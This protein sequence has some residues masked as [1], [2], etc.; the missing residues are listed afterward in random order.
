MV[1]ESPAL[2]ELAWI[3]WNLANRSA[4]C[5]A[6]RIDCLYLLAESDDPLT[7]QLAEKNQ[8][9]L[10]D[11]RMTFVRSLSNSLIVPASAVVRE[12][13][14]EDLGALRLIALKAHRDSRFYFDPHFDRA[15]CDL[16]YETS[17]EKSI[18]GFAKEVLVAEVDRKTVAYVTI[19]LN[20]SEAQ[21]GLLGV[22]E[23]HQGAGV[24]SRLVTHSLSWAAEAALNELV[25]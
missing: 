9:L 17:I 7:T 1:A 2:I 21:I 10:A 25:S 18:R 16:L 5:G 24:G 11:V 3:P 19:N 13:R 6:N 8:F 4:W 12:A 22:A 14:E 20:G 15:K 23:G